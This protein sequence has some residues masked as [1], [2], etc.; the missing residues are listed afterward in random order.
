MKRED[1]ALCAREAAGEATAEE[2]A[3]LARRAASDP[4]F[5][6][7]L[8]RWR[9][10]WSALELEPPAAPP[11]GFATRVAARAHAEGSAVALAPFG[12]PAL[13]SAT[14]ALL[15]A[16]GVAMGAAV[17]T[18]VPEIAVDE[19]GLGEEPASLAD[20]FLAASD[21]LDGEVEP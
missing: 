4:D 8:A 1:E 20:D 10:T 12:R 11:P 5:A 7:E 13:A 15:V 16:A 2:R 3:E 21:L 17:V 9:R 14:A 19:L 18:L 6:R